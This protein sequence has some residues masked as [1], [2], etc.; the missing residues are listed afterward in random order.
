MVKKHQH[1]LQTGRE[2]N[3]WVKF[4]QILDKVRKKLQNIERCSLQV[5]FNFQYVKFC[6]IKGIIIRGDNFIQKNAINRFNWNRN[7]KKAIF[8]HIIGISIEF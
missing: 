2:T 3:V 8:N 1:E 4:N 5:Q 7:S 6:V